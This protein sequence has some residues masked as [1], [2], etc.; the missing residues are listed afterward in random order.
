MIQNIPSHLHL[1]FMRINERVP[2]TFWF[3]KM[4]TVLRSSARQFPIPYHSLVASNQ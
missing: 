1:D 4:E 3:L 2:E